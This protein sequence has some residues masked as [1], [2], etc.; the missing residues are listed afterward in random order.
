[1]PY[2][3]DNTVGSP[4]FGQNVYYDP[5][6]STAKSLYGSVSSGTASAPVVTGVAATPSVPAIIPSTSGSAIK[7]ATPDLIQFKE[8]AVPI[9]YMTDLIFEDIGGQEII[10]ISRNDLVNGQRVKYTPIKNISQVGV[11]YNPQNIFSI[12]DTSSTYFNN[13]SI[14]FQEKVPEI[15]A[16]TVADQVTSVVYIDETT[17]DVVVNVVNMRTGEQVEISVVDQINT[18]SDILY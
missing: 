17:G 6:I 15:G 14:H 12:T 10:S 3:I 5:N 18:V 11:N 13:Y 2:Y 16:N 9:E 8:D 7:P 4:T 1:M